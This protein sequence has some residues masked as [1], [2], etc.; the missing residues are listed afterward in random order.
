MW[1]RDRVL[2]CPGFCPELL[3]LASTVVLG[4]VWARHAAPKRPLHE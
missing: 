4:D 2:C 1:I 3:F